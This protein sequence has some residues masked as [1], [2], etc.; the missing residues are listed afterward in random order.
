MSLDLGSMNV[1]V[2]LVVRTVVPVAPVPV[3]LVVLVVPQVA[4]AR[5]VPVGPPL[6][7]PYT[8]SGPTSRSYPVPSSSVPTPVPHNGRM[9]PRSSWQSRSPWKPWSSGDV[10]LSL[11]SL[12]VGPFSRIRSGVTGTTPMTVPPT[13]DE[14][15]AGLSGPP[16][17]LGPPGYPGPPGASGERGLP[18]TNGPSGIPSSFSVRSL[19]QTL[20]GTQATSVEMV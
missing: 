20:L 14:W 4:P 1:R 5:V 10:S 13:P 6:S 19:S 18:G 17:R 3:V 9:E 16:G 2:V 15:S 8:Q 12:S 7:S 11:S